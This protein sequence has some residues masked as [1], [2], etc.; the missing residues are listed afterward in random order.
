MSRVVAAS[1][2][3]LVLDGDRIALFVFKGPRRSRF[4]SFRL[5]CFVTAT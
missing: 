5:I 3:A 2:A 4:Y 1:Y